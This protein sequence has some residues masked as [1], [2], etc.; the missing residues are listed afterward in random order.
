MIWFIAVGFLVR[1]V[2]AM[3]SSPD[4]HCLKMHHRRIDSGDRANNHVD[5][6]RSSFLLLIDMELKRRYGIEVVYFGDVSRC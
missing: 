5:A 4:G 1:Q 3:P 2:L 6:F